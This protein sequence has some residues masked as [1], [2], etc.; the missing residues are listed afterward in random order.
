MEPDNHVS[1]S[2]R[3]SRVEQ[4]KVKDMDNDIQKID[5]LRV[6]QEV[7]GYIMDVK[8]DKIMVG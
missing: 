4:K 7:K 1:L 8:D 5:D 2:V 6:G 3:P